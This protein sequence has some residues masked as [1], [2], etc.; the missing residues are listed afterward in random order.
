[1]V[2]KLNVEDPTVAS[3][4]PAG[5]EEEEEEEEEEDTIP[6]ITGIISTA[7][8][9]PVKIEAANRVIIGRVPTTGALATTGGLAT[10]GVK[11]QRNGASALMCLPNPPLH[12]H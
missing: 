1:M 7:T 3:R 12:P 4:T 9:K 8:A 5:G 2:G 6:E 11:H 10:T